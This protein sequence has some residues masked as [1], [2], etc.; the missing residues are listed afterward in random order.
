MQ[1]NSPSHP[2]GQIASTLSPKDV[3]PTST[4]VITV[5]PQPICSIRHVFSPHRTAA[6]DRL[7]PSEQRRAAERHGAFISAVARQFRRRIRRC[8]THVVRSARQLEHMAQ[9]HRLLCTSRFLSSPTARIHRLFPRSRRRAGSSNRSLVAQAAVQFAGFSGLRGLIEVALI[10]ARGALHRLY[11]SLSLHAPTALVEHFGPLARRQ[12]RADSLAL[13][14]VRAGQRVVVVPCALRPRAHSVAPRSVYL[15]ANPR[16]YRRNPPWRS[17]CRLAGTDDSP[18][19]SFRWGRTGW[20][21]N[22]SGFAAR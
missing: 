6:L 14:A 4:P 16:T 22:R 11:A 8:E 9:T 10:H 5:A 15:E 20:R 2:S 1:L 13:L 19:P 7:A 17:T 12:T 3:R 21:T 18:I